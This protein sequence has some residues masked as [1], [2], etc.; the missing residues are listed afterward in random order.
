VRRY[1][2]G[3]F[4]VAWE[5]RWGKRDARRRWKLFLFLLHLRHGALFGA[6]GCEVY[7]GSF[8]LFSLSGVETGS[9]NIEASFE[10]VGVHAPARMVG[11]A[12]LCGYELVVGLVTK[13]LSIL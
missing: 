5:R 3:V 9:F 7:N 4:Q 6:A 10:S 13:H 11:A 8:V 1:D 12:R 2:G